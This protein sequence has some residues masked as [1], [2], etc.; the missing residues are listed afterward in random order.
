MHRL[1]VLVENEPSILNACE[2][3]LRVQFPLDGDG[4]AL[5]AHTPEAGTALAAHAA[6]ANSPDVRLFAKTIN[7]AVAFADELARQP[8]GDT[9]IAIVSDG[10]VEGST[11]HEN[12]LDFLLDMRVRFG[13]QLAVAVILS[14]ESDLVD[15]ARGHGIKA[16]VKGRELSAAE[17]CAR[18]FNV[19]RA[20]R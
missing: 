4:F 8:Y 12:G 11:T 2:R 6:L 17:V 3:R 16:V 14:S 10:T 1:F 15:R 19:L 9:H 20:L 5:L 7:A 13:E 18:A